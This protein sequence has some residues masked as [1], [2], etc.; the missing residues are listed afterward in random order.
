[1]G[2]NFYYDLLSFQFRFFNKFCIRHFLELQCSYVAN[3]SLK[4]SFQRLSI[5]GFS[6]VDLLFRIHNAMYLYMNLVELAS[7]KKYPISTIDHCPKLLYFMLAMGICC[8]S[9]Y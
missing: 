4:Y 5:D 7:L 1:M 6:I 3:I 9:S 2:T 8:V